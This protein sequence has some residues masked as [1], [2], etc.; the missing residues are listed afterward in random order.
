MAEGDGGR[1]REAMPEIVAAYESAIVKGYCRARFLILRE[2]F[3]REIAQYLPR[4]G[5]VLELG[6]GFGLFTLLFA[7][8][9]PEASFLAIDLNDRRIEMARRAAR[10]LGIANVEFRRGDA[11]EFRPG[12]SFDG[13]YTMDLIHHMDPA[14][15]DEL[16]SRVHEAMRAPSV[17]VV[18]DVDDRPLHKALFTRALDFAMAPRDRVEYRS[19]ERMRGELER[20]GWNVASHAMVDWLPYP[21]RIYVCRK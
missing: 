1:I 16:L 5:R 19:E 11:G 15:A 3:T 21:H 20:I 17:F 12:E 8:L 10:S 2:R 7:R 4:E 13:G 9:R 6:C 18:K 14:R